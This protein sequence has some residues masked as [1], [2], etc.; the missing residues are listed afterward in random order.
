MKRLFLCSQVHFVVESIAAKLGDEVAKKMVFINTCVRDKVRSNDAMEWHELNKS[1]LLAVGFTYD[2]YDIADK[3]PEQL[4]QDLEKYD[5]MYVEGGNTFY[6]QLHSQ[7]NG[8]G[9]YVERRVAEGM[10]YIGTSAGSIIAGPDT[11]SGS[12]PGKSPA[13]Y[14]L[15]DTAGFQLVNFVV[16]PHWG[17]PAKLEMYRDFKIPIAYNSPHPFILLNDNQYVEVRDDLY[18]IVDVTNE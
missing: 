13:D 16:C 14:Q 5:L 17:D 9:D 8:F 15:T 10:V 11:I 1:R 6:L 4:K 18:R 2:F 3:T 12:R 7:R